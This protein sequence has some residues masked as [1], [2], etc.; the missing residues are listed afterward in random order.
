[1]KIAIVVQGRFHA[2]DLARELIARGNDIT[3]LTN[4]PKWVAKRFGVP[5]E[6][7]KT[8]LSHGMAS[9]L[10]WRLHQH[11]VVEA[12][13]RFFHPLFGRWA[14]RE[15]SGSDWDAVHCW[16]GVAEEVFQSLEGKRS[17]RLLMRGSAH[18]AAQ[19]RLLSEEEARVGVRLDRPGDWIVAREQR[20]YAA[21]SRIIVLSSF[22]YNSFVDEGVDPARLRIVSLGARLDTFKPSLSTVEARC[23]RIIQGQPLNVLFVGNLSFQKGMFDLAAVIETLGGRG[24]S[25]RLVGPILSEAKKLVS[26]LHD[27]ATIVGKVRQSDLPAQYRWADIFIFPTIQDGYAQV[28]AQAAASGLPVLATTNCGASDFIQ[29][30]ETGWLVPIRRPD[31]LTEKLHWCSQHRIELAKIV[32]QSSM[33]RKVRDWVDVA[34]DFEAVCLGAIRELNCG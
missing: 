24:F 9:R 22:A 30:S 33:V 31:A 12:P 28:I 27:K 17:L 29:E 21:A 8:F 3:L 23:Q 5:P 4:Y 26:A 7:V 13:E 1:M 19:S 15:L 20:E 14:S 11:G 2:F 10:V 16:S 6:R 34:A 18:I 32:E 25:F